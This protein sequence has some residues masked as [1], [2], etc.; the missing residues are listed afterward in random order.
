MKKLL[1]LVILTVSV[2]VYA[3]DW[4]KIDA[5]KEEIASSDSNVVP[6]KMST[7]NTIYIENE[8]NVNDEKAASIDKISKQ[9][10][11]WENIKINK[12]KILVTKSELIIAVYPERFVYKKTNLLPYVTS[13]IM[14]SYKDSILRY[15][16]RIMRNNIFMKISGVFLNEEL[17]AKKVYEAVKDPQSFIKRRD[18][19]FFLAQID[20][21]DEEMDKLEARIMTL[22]KENKQLKSSLKEQDEK[23][24]KLVV[25]VTSFQNDRF[26][27]NSKPIDKKI[28]RAVI[29]EKEANPNI[30]VKETVENLKKK[31]VEVS[32][33][34]VEIIFAVYYNE[35]PEK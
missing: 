26:F 4:S 31:N 22:E 19:D 23:V 10:F 35:F 8:S 27:Y 13:G 14:F 30:T 3:Y 7:G 16:F 1:I 24:D 25:A 18:A 17:L 2:N 15:D 32:A 11:S 29:A 12:L 6:V 34:Q 33:K 20:K 5:A 21:I 9:F 28:I